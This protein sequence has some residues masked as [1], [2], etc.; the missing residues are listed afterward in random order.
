MIEQL[1][2][3]KQNILNI[4]SLFNPLA[5]DDINDRRII[6]GSSSNLINFAVYKYQPSIELWTKMRENTWQVDKAQ[7]IRDNISLLTDSEKYAIE[8]TLSFLTF[9][10]SFNT[11]QLPNIAQYITDPNYKCCLVEQSAQ[12]VLHSVAYSK[13]FQTYWSIS[14]EIIRIFNIAKTDEFLLKRNLHLIKIFENF[15]ENP[16]VY[17][18]VLVL[19]ATYILEGFFFYN[20]F[21]FFYNL[22]NQ[23]KMMNAAVM[24][25]YIE[26]DELTH[27]DLFRLIITEIN[28]E[29][30]N[31]LTVEMV[32]QMFEEFIIEEESWAKYIYKNINGITDTTIYKFTRYLAN[33]RIVE[34]GFPGIPEYEHIENPYSH[35]EKF[36]ALNFNNTQQNFFEQTINHYIDP[37]ALDWDEYNE[38]CTV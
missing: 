22:A 32:H 5:S 27:L 33:T 9:L 16:N 10:D 30:N 37:S 7:L 2:L 25:Q 15:K 20:G 18:F 31:I 8:A 24:I 14:S 13:M 17:N 35:L 4:Q 29:N 26:R 38:P 6:N 11:A 23:G 21:Y 36:S 34:L 28:K 3:N 1:V 12:E 19:L